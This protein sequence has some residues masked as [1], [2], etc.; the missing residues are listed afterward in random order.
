MSEHKGQTMQKAIIFDA[1]LIGIKLSI[2][3]LAMPESFVSLWSG[4]IAIF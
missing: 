2:M 1:I 3:V 4:L